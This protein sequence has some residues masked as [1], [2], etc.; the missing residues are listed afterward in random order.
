MLKIESL[1]AF[2]GKSHILHGVDLAVPR[3]IE[4]GV[5][6]LEN[7]Y[8]YNLDDLATIAA[9]NLAAFLAG[10]ALGLAAAMLPVPAVTWWRT[11]LR[12]RE[13]PGPKRLPARPMAAGWSAIPMHRSSLLNTARS[14]APPV[15]CSPPKD[16]PSCTPIMST[17]AASP[18]NSAP[19]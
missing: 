18:M 17:A 2:Y 19:C 5:A 16:R 4:P 1:Q 9:K 8:L 11:W 10:M 7:V 15:R 6:K 12:Q 14:L 3:D 13:P